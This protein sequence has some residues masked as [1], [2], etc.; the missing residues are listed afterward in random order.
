MLFLLVPGFLTSLFYFLSREI[1]ATI[2]FHNL[3]GMVG[4][5]SNLEHPD[6]LKRP[7]YPLYLLM[8]ISVLALIGVEL[9]LARR[10]NTDD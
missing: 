5:I 9:L 3:Q 10:A 6:I 8:L 2:L 1:Y 7:L 4:V